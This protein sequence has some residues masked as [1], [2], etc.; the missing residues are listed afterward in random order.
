MVEAGSQQGVIV[1][2]CTEKLCRGDHRKQHLTNTLFSRL[3]YCR[4]TRF[5]TA[6]YPEI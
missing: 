2:T 4:K 6:D 3:N 1:K 5:D